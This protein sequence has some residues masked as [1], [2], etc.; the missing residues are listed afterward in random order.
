MYTEN[1]VHVIN[2]RPNRK[3]R[4]HNK[5]EEEKEGGRNERI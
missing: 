2:I 4:T 3:I 1:A 5:E